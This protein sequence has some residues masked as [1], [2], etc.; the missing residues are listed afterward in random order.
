VAPGAGSPAGKVTALARL[1]IALLIAGLAVQAGFMVREVHDQLSTPVR[2]PL[3]DFLE[4]ADAVIPAGDE[5]VV[6][7]AVRSDDA[8]YFL[9]PRRQVTSGFDQASLEA[10]GA[11][12]VIVTADARP[13]TLHG[14][15]SWYRVRLTTPSGRLLELTG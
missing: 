3:R 1:A 10:S 12:W 2:H 14:Q 5:Y 13:A 11:R 15:Q 8:R 4:Q 6:T 7:S 9:Y